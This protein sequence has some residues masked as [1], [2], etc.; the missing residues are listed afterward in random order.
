MRD[1][2]VNPQPLWVRALLDKDLPPTERIVLVALAWHQGSKDTC[3]PSEKALAAELGLSER[4]VRRIIQD[5]IA[6]G[7]LRVT[8]PANQGRGMANT[9]TVVLVAEGGHVDPPSEGQKA[10]VVGPLSDKEGGQPGSKRGSPVSSQH[11]R[12]TEEEEGTILF[13]TP[14]V[15]EVRAYATHRGFPGFD[16][17]KF[18]EHY[19][20]ADWRD[21]QG[22]PVRNWKH[23]FIWVWEP[24]LKE[25]QVDHAEPQRGD[26]DWYPTEEQVIAARGGCETE[27][28]E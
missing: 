13:T 14:S 17:E 12:N 26:P 21:S 16:A 10:D 20:A 5:L 4:N 8:R 19:A 3:W 25:K 6:K 1:N 28:S 9:Y 18:I 2:R 11:R 24:K 15:A 23:K 7:H 22:R 27:V